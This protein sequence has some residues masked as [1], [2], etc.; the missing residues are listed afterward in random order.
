M[1]KTKTRFLALA[2]IL[3]LNL[4]PLQQVGAVDQPRMLIPVGATVGIQLDTQGVVVA[5]AEG[6]KVK[7]GDVI[8]EM[9]GQPVHCGADLQ[10][11]AAGL[12]DGENVDLVV[13]RNGEEKEIHQAVTVG[14]D[15]KATMGLWLRD[16]ISGIGTVT[17]V[18]PETGF[19]GALGHG[20]N[21]CD[22]GI[23]LPL[24]QGL[25][26]RTEVNAVLK[27]SAGSPGQLCGG[28]DTSRTLGT[29]GQNTQQGIFG[30]ME[31]LSWLQEP[32]I[33]VAEL[34]E[35]CLGEAQILSNVDGE[36]VERYTVE[37]VRL[38]Q[39]E[40]NGRDMMLKV[41]D[42]RLLAQTGGIVQGMSGSPILQNGKLIGAVTHVLV[43][44][45]EKGYG[46]S[47]ISMLE[48]AEN[49]A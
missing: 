11:I 30:T 22:S 15:G 25:V 34:D 14:A 23:L 2:L 28:V 19:Y 7:A 21:D 13:L 20:I 31:D 29:I 43:D 42:E 17:F 24:R 47:L 36:T 8:L 1:K 6:G 5:R 46:I 37:I 4:L 45:P 41:T 10:A 32:A 44:Q 40:N 49:A 9:E 3:A 48:A 39:G 35:I 26:T 16:Q 18:D 12:Q 38:Y 27:G 33:E